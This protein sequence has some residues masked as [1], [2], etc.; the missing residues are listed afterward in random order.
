MT[1]VAKISG[2]A[3]NMMSN[4]VSIGD[5]IGSYDR[6]EPAVSYG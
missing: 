3:K 2:C 1:C 4:L 6:G 5:T